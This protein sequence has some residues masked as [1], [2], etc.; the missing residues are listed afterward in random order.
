[1]HVYNHDSEDFRVMHVL[2]VNVCPRLQTCPIQITVIEPYRTWPLSSRNRYLLSSHQTTIW[3]FCVLMT[4][5]LIYFSCTYWTKAWEHEGFLWL[6]EQIRRRLFF[7]CCRH[8]TQSQRILDWPGIGVGRREVEY[9]PHFTNLEPIFNQHHSGNGMINGLSKDSFH[10][11]G[12]RRR[13][14]LGL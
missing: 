6:Y 13:K 5:P 9:V 10:R 11:T 12:N 14:P 8:D 7:K 4:K 2:S 1:M 3:G